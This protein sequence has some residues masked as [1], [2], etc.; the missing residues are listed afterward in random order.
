MIRWV[1]S[2]L[3]YEIAADMRGD[4]GGRPSVRRRV[5]YEHTKIRMI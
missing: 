4:A 3:G 5:K 2:R 1:E